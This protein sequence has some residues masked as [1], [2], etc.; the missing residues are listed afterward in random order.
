MNT[1]VLMGL[2]LW[3]QNYKN[4]EKLGANTNLATI[5]HRHHKQNIRD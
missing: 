3:F 4:R 1:L 5:I 2:P